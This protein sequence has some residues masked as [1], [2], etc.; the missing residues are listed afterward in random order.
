VTSQCTKSYARTK[1]LLYDLSYH[2][3]LYS[4]IG[5]IVAYATFTNSLSSAL[6]S[7]NTY[8]IRSI[9]LTSSPLSSSLKTSV[10]SKLSIKGAVL[11]SLFTSVCAKWLIIPLQRLLSQVQCRAYVVAVILSLSEIILLYSCC[12]KKGLVYITITVLSSCQPSSY[13]KYTSA[14]IQLSCDV[15]LV[16]NVKCIFYICCLC[17]L[18]L[19]KNT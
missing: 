6:S 3:S 19:N 10:I 17:P 15:C 12:V 16:S 14:N 9:T 11:L 13:S 2:S 4:S 1:L 5:S 8:L 7:Y 18:C